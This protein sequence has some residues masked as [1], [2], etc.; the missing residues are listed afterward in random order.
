MFSSMRA[1]LASTRYLVNLDALAASEVVDPLPLLA[2]DVLAFATQGGAR[3][4]WLEAEIGSVT[5][6]KKADLVLLRTDTYSMTPLNYVAGA[7][8]ESGNPEL[9]ANVW[10]N[11]R[12][13]KRN[14]TLVDH[15]LADIRTQAQQ[16]TDALFG[17][18]GVPDPGRWRPLPYE[19]V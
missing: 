8:I 1:V 6:G 3:A 2:S 5:V 12:L 15:K 9:V 11:G 19:T 16:A 10:V 18:A 14:G 17:R 4:A 13:V 7:V